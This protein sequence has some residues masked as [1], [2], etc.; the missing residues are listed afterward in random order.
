MSGRIVTS[1]P[2]P[3]SGF[4]RVEAARRGT[5]F[6]Q[7]VGDAYRRHAQRLRE[8]WR[9]GGNEASGVPADDPF[10]R[11]TRSSGGGGA[12][13]VTLRGFNEAALGLLDELAV[14]VGCVRED[15]RPNRSAVIAL[16]L[17]AAAA[18]E[19]VEP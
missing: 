11:P 14:E 7:V 16:L 10:A 18:A 2:A 15:D 12:V 6:D 8:G 1:L 9:P 4:L 17:A 3:V 13:H 5:T 19:S